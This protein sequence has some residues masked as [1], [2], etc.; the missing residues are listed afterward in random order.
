MLEYEGP[1]ADNKGLAGSTTVGNGS[2]AY[3]VRSQLGSRCEYHHLPSDGIG[4]EVM[5]AATRLRRALPVE[6]ELE[7]H[8]F[9]GDAIHATSELLPPERVRL[10]TRHRRTWDRQPSRDVALHRS[11]A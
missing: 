1:P 9:G 4:P 8:A 3:T 7:E 2:W 6:P 11:H 5:G 10:G